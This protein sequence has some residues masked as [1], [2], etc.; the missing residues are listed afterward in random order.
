[1]DVHPSEIGVSD[2]GGNLV[3]QTVIIV[4]G[5]ITSF[6]STVGP[7]IEIEMRMD[8]VLKIPALHPGHSGDHARPLSAAALVLNEELV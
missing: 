4:V 7:I 2:L 1:M 8:Y 6:W 5:A 3:A